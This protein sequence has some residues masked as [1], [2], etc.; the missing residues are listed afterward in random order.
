MATN[1]ISKLSFKYKFIAVSSKKNKILRIC[2]ILFNI[3]KHKNHVKIVFIDTFSSWAFWFAYISSLLCNMLNIS[4]IPVIRGGNMLI[5]IQKSPQCAN[6]IFNHSY[7]NVS[8][9]LY[10]Y[11]VF[12]RYGYSVKYIPNFIPIENYTFRKRNGSGHNILWVRSFHKIYNPRMAIRVLEKLID[13]YPNATL[14]MVGPDKDGSM[15]SCRIKAKELGV[16]SRVTFTDFLTKKEWVNLSSKYDIFINTTNIDNHPVSVIEAMALGFPIVST[17]VGGL[18]FLHENGVDAILVEP[19]DV[20]WMAKEIKN[21]FKNTLIAGQ[22]SSNARLK[23]EKFS[24]ENISKEWVAL[25][26]QIYF[27]NEKC[28]L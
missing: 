7:I 24:W 25:L 16:V 20:K 17:K 15:E 11:E 8:P 18:S 21:I 13:E 10:L 9:S 1:I 19:N 28:N 14:C 2:D 6:F 26:D 12:Q 3:I 5:R 27:R 22:L 4:Y 23:A